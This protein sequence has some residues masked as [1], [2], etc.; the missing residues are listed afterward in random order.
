[1]L[2][3]WCVMR[4]R[5]REI[6]PFCVRY[7]AANTFTI[8]WMN[9]NVI[10]FPFCFSI[11]WNSS[12][13]FIYSVSLPCS[14]LFFS[15]KKTPVDMFCVWHTNTHEKEFMGKY[16]KNERILFHLRTDLPKK[17]K[18]GKKSII[19]LKRKLYSFAFLSV[20]VRVFVRVYLSHSL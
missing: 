6:S 5:R 14:Y 15:T 12:F 7:W 4:V 1:M 17:K 8:Q 11:K 20:R 19:V 2:V 9:F 10:I 18:R 13:L 3:Q 16:A